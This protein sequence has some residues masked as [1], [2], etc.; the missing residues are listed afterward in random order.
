MAYS[1]YLRDVRINLGKQLGT[2]N[3]VLQLKNA[4]RDGLVPVVNQVIATGD[5]R[6]DTLSGTYYGDAK[7]WWVLAAASGIGWGLQIPPGTVINIVKLD[8]VLAIVR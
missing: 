3:S 5:D 7:Y 1:R 8:D 6:L 2:A 4:I